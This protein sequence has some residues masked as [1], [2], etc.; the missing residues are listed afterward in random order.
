MKLTFLGFAH[1]ALANSTKAKGKGKLM[2]QD[3]YDIAIIGGGPAGLSAALAI[4]RIGRTA[5]IFD[6]DKGRN[7]PAAHM[8]NFPTREGTP[9]REFRELVKKELAKYNEITFRNEKVTSV[10]KV[11]DHFHINGNIRVRKVLLA[12][13]I[14]D[15]LPP[16]PGLRELWG[17]SVFHCPFCHG[18][19]FKR[20]KFGLLATDH[21]YAEHM[22]T[23]ILSLTHDLTIFTNG[24]IYDL[25]DG[26]KKRVKMIHRRPV[27]V[28]GDTHE[29]KYVELEDGNQI[30][31]QAM[32]VKPSLE[33]T[34]DL[35]KK[36][37]C[38]FTETGL[39]KVDSM[40]MTSV[41]GVYAAGDIAEPM[42]SVL[43]S[44]SSGQKAGAMMSYQIMN[45]TLK[46]S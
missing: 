7:F 45:D 43:N 35:G 17:N 11:A 30:E 28:S 15:N 40:G 32:I 18:H 39:Y 5:I 8:M 14:K 12:H 44:C 34:S 1:M 46:E 33:L 9:P 13:G 25:P 38:V 26:L 37:G 23:F 3:S 10:E 22:A 31:V 16:I 41:L 20:K 4:G 6:E 24:E 36:L 19:E 27:K 29:I 2:K 42:Q 21:H